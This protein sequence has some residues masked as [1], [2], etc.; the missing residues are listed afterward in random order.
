MK[1]NNYDGNKISVSIDRPPC[2]I[3]GRLAGG[4]TEDTQSDESSE[5]EFLVP[6]EPSGVIGINDSN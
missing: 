6:S 3:E 4:Q 2:R 5:D 1:D